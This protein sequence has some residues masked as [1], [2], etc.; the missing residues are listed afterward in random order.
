M[1]ARSWGHFRSGAELWHAGR[2][3]AQ[4]ASELPSEADSREPSLSV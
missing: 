3:A 4:L 2:T 1:L